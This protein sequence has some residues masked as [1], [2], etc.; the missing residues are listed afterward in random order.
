MHKIYSILLLAAALITACDRSTDIGRFDNAV[1]DSESN[2]NKFRQITFTLSIINSSGKYLN[3][4]G[5][6]SIQLTV[7]GKYWGVFSSEANDTS[8]LTDQVVNDIGLS[9]SKVTYLV[10]APYTLR[11]TNLPTAGDVVD[12]LNDRIVLTPG[13]YVCGITSIQ[14]HD[15]KNRWVTLKPQYYG[16][17]SVVQNSTSAYVGD[18]L[19]TMN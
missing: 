12:Y 14:F 10:V 15:L 16:V 11:T 6:D 3:T 17:F 2:Q 19:I 13:D 9:S 18:I 7:N 5:I 1:V 4:A 8:G